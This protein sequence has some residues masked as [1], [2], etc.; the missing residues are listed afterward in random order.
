M[1][2][3]EPNHILTRR[4]R[5]HLAD[6]RR[7]RTGAQNLETVRR[8]TRAALIAAVVSAMGTAAAS[9][10]DG[11]AKPPATASSIDNADDLLT[12]GAYAQAADVYASLAS[13][14]RLAERATLGLARCR[15]ATGQYRRAIEEL[16]KSATPSTPARLVLLAKLHNRVGEYDDTLRF[17]KK[18]IELDA[19]HAAARRVLAETLE[20]LGRRD[21]ALTA[22]RWFDEQLVVGGELR[23]DAAWLTDMAVGYVRFSRLSRTDLVRRTEFALAELLQPAYERI[24][25]G[26]LPA[27]IAAADLLRER[28]N[29]DETD[30]S[31]SDYAAA[32]RIN[33]HLPE[34]HVGLGEIALTHWNFEKVERRVEIALEVNPRFAPALHLSAKN[35]I[36]QRRYKQAQQTCDRVLDTNPNDVIALS[37]AAAACACRYDSDGVEHYT[38]RIAAI[39][40]RCATLHRVMA[41]AYSGIR[42][43]EDAEREYLRAISIDPTDANARTE[44][45]MMYMQWGR[46]TRARDALDAA[47]VLDSFNERTQF[48]LELLEQLE[49]MDRVETKHAIV[50]FDALRDP[51]LGTLVG[52]YL[53]EIYD[54][55]TGDFD[56]KLE[57][58][59]IIEFFP[60]MRAFAVRIT[61]K[62]WIHTV[63]ACTGRVIALASPRDAAHSVRYNIADVIKHEFTHTVTLAATQNRIPHWFTEGLAVFQEDSDRSFAWM[64]LLSD[65]V[66]RDRLFTLESIDW[67]FIRPRRP[68][69]RQIAYAQ[70]EW[71]CEYI[72]QRFGYEM[73][74][75]MLMELR[76][77]KTQSDLFRDQ[78]GISPEDF[79]RDFRLWARERVREWGYDPAPPDDVETL[80]VRVGADKEN[81]S[82]LGR[83]A[84][85]ELEEGNIVRAIP[86]ARRALE[87]NENQREAL[88]T[89]GTVLSAFARQSGDPAERRSYDAEARPLL[90][91]LARVDAEGWTAPKLLAEIALRGDRLDDATRWFERLQSRCPAD[92]VSWRGLAGILLQRRQYDRA[93]PQLVELARLDQSDPEVPVQ[94]ADI[95]RKAGRFH[96]AR[97]WYRRANFIDPFDTH[98]HRAL[99]ELAKR[100]GDARAALSEFTLLTRLEPQRA[101]FFELAALAARDAGDNDAA[102]AFARQAVR[103]DP[104]S[105]AR[106][107]IP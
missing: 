13:D 102:L 86:A 69:D 56:T 87:L 57:E 10:A 94:I 103:L 25:R 29:N 14:T 49:K 99:G 60:T 71:M 70:S 30:G 98:T 22:Y 73:I 47:W 28:F 97:Y 37:L 3:L 58:K 82:L 83:L 35:L 79:D 26:Y 50:K 32:L 20:L 62:P 46:E 12:R 1:A 68:N 27:R 55:V 105:P 36:L 106:S 40:P 67:G 42:Q 11:A 52:N 65:T 61:G 48:T 64:E 33:E 74:N 18:A 31:V 85:A 15:L 17:A 77:K 76:K 24:D 66:R 93:L 53:D 100:A 95:H 43:Y 38:K 5:R 101:E 92:P 16:S 41:D 4:P 78:L 104:N 45:G 63:G 9:A 51:G 80:R 34:A 44:L 8:V 88:Q 107:L 72:V 7:M 59:T 6:N 23:R 89:L 54:A 2:A 81:A 91:R 21:E 19:G 90:E 84:L 39:N 96:E 75:T